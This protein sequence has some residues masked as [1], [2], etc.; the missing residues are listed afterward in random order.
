MAQSMSNKVTRGISS[1]TIVTFVMGVTEILVF[2]IM[3]R[4]LNKE[5]FGYYAAITAIMAVFSS[6]A[7][8]GIG[9][10]IVQHKEIDKKYLDNAFSLSFVIGLILTIMLCALSAPISTMVVDSSIQVPLIIVSCSLLLNCATNVPRSI[11]HR[12]RMFFRMGLTSMISLIISSI[13]AIV[14]ALNG[15]GFYAIIGKLIANSL[16]MYFISLFFAKTN[17]NFAWNAKV[18]KKI[19]SFSGWLMASAVFRNLAHS[20]DSL[21]MPRLMSVSL[22]GAYNRPQGFIG[23]I[24]SQ[25]N[26]IF[27]TALFPILSEIQEDKSAIKSAFKTS[28]YYL[29]IFAMIL[30]ICFI[31][32][33]ELIVR[34][35]FGEQWI[36][37]KYIFMILSLALIFNIDIRLTDCYLRSLA[38]TKSQFIFRIIEFVL[39]LICLTIGSSWGLVGFSVGSVSAVLL[40]TIFKLF[41]ISRKVDVGFLETLS[42]IASSWRAGILFVPVMVLGFFLFP[43]SIIGNVL[44]ALLMF[45]LFLCVFG[46]FPSLVGKK[47]QQ[48]IHPKMSD[49]FNNFFS[50]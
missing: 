42:C 1:Q 10:A 14:L 38:L 33:G 27:D 48:E 19:F 24:S 26:G 39:K 13:F 37:L 15:F 47:Y 45:L 46:F 21:I 40:T 43:S 30:S 6:F 23:S 22:L 20:V 18:L 35:F 28:V 2:S 44:N 29:N 9:S 41:Y 34:I 11:L 16:M 3:S 8:T 25:V 31:F 50:R 4:L 5:D 36:E 7:E 49:R 32:N 12:N 17:F